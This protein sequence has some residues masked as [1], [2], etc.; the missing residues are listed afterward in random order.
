MS[1]SDDKRYSESDHFSVVNQ[2]HYAARRSLL[3][4]PATWAP[5]RSD[6]YAPPE[7]FA[8]GTTLGPVL[9]ELPSCVSGM[10]ARSFAGGMA[11]PSARIRLSPITSGGT[12]RRIVCQVR[13]TLRRRRRGVTKETTD[14]G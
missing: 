4:R 1:S 13:V 12:S 10:V 7:I 8:V 5:Q 11:V 9:C 6:P 14:D 2:C 3:R